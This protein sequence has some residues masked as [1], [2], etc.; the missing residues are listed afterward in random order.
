ML[1][2]ITSFL[3]YIFRANPDKV[4][5]W[6]SPFTDLSD[7]ETQVIANALWYSDTKQANDYLV[8]LS[9]AAE[10]EMKHVFAS[11]L[12]E[13]PTPIDEIPIIA[14]AVLDMLWAAFMA[15][16][17]EQYV[18][19]I[20]SALPYANAEDDTAERMIGEAASWSLK[21]NAAHNKKVLSIAE[22]ELH[23]QPEDVASILREIIEEVQES[24]LGA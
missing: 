15:T 16:G 3:S 1:E 23:K 13:Q 4:E 7:E 9:A 12:T 22:S 19:R 24:G 18:V 5:A 20:I 11:L 10:I 17:E 21:S 8:T 6:L 2:T 14:P